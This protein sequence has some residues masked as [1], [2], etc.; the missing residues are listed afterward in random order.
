MQRSYRTRLLDTL[1]SIAYNR[2]YFSCLMV[3]SMLATATKC[4]MR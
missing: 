4:E 2:K 3:F 1:F